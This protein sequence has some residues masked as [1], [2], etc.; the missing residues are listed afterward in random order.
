MPVYTVFHRSSIP[1]D[2]KQALAK[3]LTDL[4]SRVTET[5]EEAVKV[6]S[7]GLDVDS[8]FSGGKRIEDYVR[9]VG[10]I[11]RGRTEEEKW[12]ILRGMYVILQVSLGKGEIQTQIIEI[13]DTKT[14]MT[15]GVLNI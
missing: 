14:V 13:D 12:E 2:K 15:N 4:H 8:F 6:M 11:R 5:P 10:Q 1:G 7:V 3:S 9:L